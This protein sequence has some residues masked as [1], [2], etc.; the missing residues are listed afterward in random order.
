MIG[1]NERQPNRTID[2]FLG[3][4]VEAVQPASGYHRSGLEAV[5]LGASMDVD[6]SG[7]AID[8]G[9]GVGVASFCAA[10]RCPDLTVRLVERDGVLAECAQEGLRRPANAS[11]APRVSLSQVDISASEEER[12]TAGFG[13]EMAGLVL[14][15]PPFH[16]PTTVRPSP[17]VQRADAHLL[18]GGLDLWFRIA[19]YALV[20]RGSV[21]AVTL[22]S[23]LPDLIGSLAGRFGDT[24]ILPLHPRSDRAAER[25][26]V[27]AVKGSRAPPKLL[28]GLVL[29]QETGA[30]Y[31][32]ELSGVLRA[33]KGLGEVHPPWRNQAH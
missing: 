8:L 21:V 1:G 10:V 18:A 16:E 3:G 28:P 11:F 13:R 23:S 32:E 20:P 4:R 15:N 14:M 33:A 5:L 19:A 24:T 7:I 30:A 26:L 17:A 25:V 31:T 2:A 12:V 9:A 29:H 6:T 22:A 27:R